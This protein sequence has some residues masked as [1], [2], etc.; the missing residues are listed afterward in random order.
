MYNNLPKTN[1]TIT[2]ATAA[3]LAKD[4]GNIIGVKDSTG[5]MTNTGEYLRLRDPLQD[6]PLFDY[7][8]EGTHAAGD[9][10]RSEAVLGFQS[11]LPVPVHKSVDMMPSAF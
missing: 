1:V 7:L 4:C 9:A 11:A 10:Q 5:D 8:G 2:P 6:K 3:R